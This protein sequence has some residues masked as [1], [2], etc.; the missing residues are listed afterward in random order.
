MEKQNF[1]FFKLTNVLWGCL[2]HYLAGIKYIYI[3]EKKIFI[4]KV[5]IRVTEVSGKQTICAATAY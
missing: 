5:Q 4:R 2:L 3:F 1:L